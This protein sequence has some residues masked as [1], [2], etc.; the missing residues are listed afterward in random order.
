M[1]WKRIFKRLR[2]I[3][4][5]KLLRRGLEG[6]RKWHRLR[7]TPHPITK[8]LPVFIGGCNRSGT[9]M[10]CAAIGKSPH[11]WAYQESELSLAFSAY[12]LRADRI[13]EWLIRHTPAPI[14]AF[15]SI[16]DS[17]FTNDLL[18]RFEGAR[19]IWVYRHYEDV[20]NSCA[21]MQWGYHLKDLVRW[22]AHDELERLGARGKHIS[23]DTVRLF[24]ELFHED[25]S[26]E[27]SACLY[28]YMRNQLYFDLDLLMDPRVLLVQY[29]DTVLNQEKA[30]RR[31]F[32]FLG[33]P[34]D[35]AI[36]DGIFASSVGK[37]SRPDI[38]PAIREICDALKARLDAH[39]ARTNDW[40]SVEN[41]LL[42]TSQVAHSASTHDPTERP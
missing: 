21:R 27:D 41:E 25:L 34:F 26:N 8:K 16:L 33:F 17:Q 37:H 20:A 2:Q 29:E 5:E 15:G 36:I 35:P 32:G 38:D 4:V 6:R 3:N 24:G 42:L 40:T 10:V 12:Y 30:F 28:W 14:V 11:G 31:I 7:R 23:A 13:I 9:N 18:S 22:V 39:Y 1:R 19:A